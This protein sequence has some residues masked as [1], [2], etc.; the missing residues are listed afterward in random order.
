MLASPALK[1]KLYVP[2]AR[3]SLAIMLAL[4]ITKALPALAFVNSYV[5]AK[6][7]THDAE[8]IKPYDEDPLITRPIAVNIL[9]ELYESVER[10]VK[11]AAAI[12]A[13]AVFN[14]WQRLG[15]ASKAHAT[16]V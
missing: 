14:I 2:F 13:N 1:V 4:G 10:L 3:Q 5:K 8:R 11:D 9:L 6:W 16:T 7:L 12:T 15:G